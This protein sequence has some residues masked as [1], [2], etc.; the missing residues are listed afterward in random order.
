MSRSIVRRLT[1]A[2][3]LVTVL[4]VAAPAMAAPVRSH[5]KTPVV[6]GGGLFDQVLSWLGSLLSGPEAQPQAPAVKSAPIGFDTDPSQPVSAESDRGAQ[7]DP[8]GGQ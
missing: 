2:I 5:F 8:N 3:A 7:I 1:A 6:L 4:C